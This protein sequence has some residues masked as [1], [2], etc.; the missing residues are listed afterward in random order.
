MGGIT[1]H[2]ADTRPLLR[3]IFDAAVAAG[4]VATRALGAFAGATQ[5]QDRLAAGKGAA[6]MAAAGERHYLDALGL[7]P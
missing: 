3:T 4:A 5:R 7:E 6:A 1:S 2:M